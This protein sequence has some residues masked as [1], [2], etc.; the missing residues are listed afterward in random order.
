[1]N[2]CEPVLRSLKVRVN[3]DEERFTK[4]TLERAGCETK[5]LPN[6]G[7]I[8]FERRLALLAKGRIDLLVNVSRRPD[9]EQYAHF[10][11]PT[12]DERVRLW[13]RRGEASKY[14]NIDLLTLVN[15]GV[16]IVAP[17]TGWFGSDYK[18]LQETSNKQ[19]VYFKEVEQG[20]ELLHK[21]RGELFLGSENFV[22]NFQPEYSD[23]TVMLPQ[24]VHRDTLH[25]MYSK[26]TVPLKTVKLID[27]AIKEQ[28]TIEKAKT[29]AL[30]NQ[31]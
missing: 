21:H 22:Q 30:S 27:V 9:R 18:D 7:D 13:A 16:K 8:T 4:Q 1:M 23:K 5:K 6:N 26:K 29:A 2:A 11:I 31:Q 25:L 20:L 28:L 17:I 10:S 3:D 19:L 24:I 14:E 15:N 12:V